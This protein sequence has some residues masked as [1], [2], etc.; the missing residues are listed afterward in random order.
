M[1]DKYYPGV[2]TS[3]VF[4]DIPDFVGN[5][6][7]SAIIANGDIIEAV[8]SAN[9]N[10]FN[11]AA[12]A[13]LKYGQDGDKWPSGIPSGISYDGSIEDEDVYYPTIPLAKNKIFLTSLP[14]DSVYRAQVNALAT[15]LGFDADAMVTE[16]KSANSGSLSFVEDVFLTP[17]LPTSTETQTGLK[18]LFD[19][20][21][22]LIER[23]QYTKEEWIDDIYGG[24]YKENEY[25]YPINET[26][27]SIYYSKKTTNT[28]NDEEFRYSMLWRYADKNTYHGVVGKV[29][30]YSINRYAGLWLR[31]QGDFGFELLSAPTINYQISETEY[32]SV[33]IADLQVTFK[34][35]GEITLPVTY[36]FGGDN[37]VIPIRRD[38]L[39]SYTGIKKSNILMESMSF[40]VF[41]LQKVKVKWYETS[42]F[43]AVV[44]VISVVAAIPTSGTSLGWGQLLD[45]AV[46][47][48]ISLLLT[49]IGEQI[50]GN[51]GAFIAAAAAVYIA[52]NGVNSLNIPS[53]PT[54]QALLAGVNQF[55]N[56]TMA[57]LEDRLTELMG[58]RDEFLSSAKE[59]LEQLRE[60]EEGLTSKTNL[61]A[62]DPLYVGRMVSYF[63]AHESPTQYYKRALEFNPG[64]LSLSAI[65]EYVETL[66]EL[67]ETPMYPSIPSYSRPLSGENYE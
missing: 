50:G 57:I 15:E 59:R 23:Q 1:S 35:K 37:C 30:T 7:T 62:Y 58:L 45:V 11:A 25:G 46:S 60:A 19:F 67:P 17:Y 9:I 42:L 8:K 56:V 29:G 28:I 24:N 26:V 65:D 36:Y 31:A 33:T 16:F 51:L 63:D 34:I 54:A 41:S 21:E 4:S 14:A 39:A 13:Y 6:V 55:S 3:S 61:A 53:M 22:L 20:G 27:K 12:D 10:N 40:I 49:E 5:A 47:I 38:I 64:V 2:A 43:S 66:L 18:Y 48:A 32:V 44:F 52:V